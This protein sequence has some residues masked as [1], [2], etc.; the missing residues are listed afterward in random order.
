MKGHSLILSLHLNLELIKEIIFEVHKMCCITWT[1]CLYSLT[2]RVVSINQLFLRFFFQCKITDCKYGKLGFKSVSNYNYKRGLPSLLTSAQV[3]L[4]CTFC[5]L[6][7]SLP[8]LLFESCAT[9]CQQSVPK[10][11]VLNRLL[12]RWWWWHIFYPFIF[13]HVSHCIHSSIH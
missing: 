5:C 4:T 9:T 11:R 2:R 12:K 1:M 7:T 8:F 10:T 3:F 6:S 13:T